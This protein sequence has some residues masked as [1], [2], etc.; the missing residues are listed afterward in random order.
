MEVEGGVSSTNILQLPRK[1]PTPGDAM[2]N[3]ITLTAVQCGRGILLLCFGVLSRS[4]HD[5]LME[6]FYTG[7]IQ[8]IGAYNWPPLPGFKIGLCDLFF[9]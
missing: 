7:A 8:V 5:N 3:S 6:Y 9:I 4:K 2:E 1:S